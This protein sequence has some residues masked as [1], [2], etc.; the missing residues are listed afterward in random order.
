MT[1]LRRATAVMTVGTVFSRITGVLRLAAVLGALGV[2]SQ[3]RLADTYNI[4]NTAPNIIYELVLGGVITSVFVPIFVELL[5]TEGRERAWEVASAIINLT[6][7]AL[8]AMTILGILA[9][10]LIA[11][12]YAS[13]LHGA[14]A[15]EQQ[16]VLTFLLRLFIPQIIFY[17]IY[18]VTAGLLN[19]HRRFGPPM[20]T[21]ALGNVAV[22]VIFVAF[23][24]AYGAVGGLSQVSNWQLILIG[25]GTTLGIVLQALTQLPFMRGLGR[26]RATL[27]VR[28]PSIRKLGRLAV[29]VIGYVVVNQI[30]Y[31]VVQKLADAQ[32][33]GYTA[34]AAA[35][36]FYM[37]PH[38]LFAVSVAT[39]LLPE[40]SA[41]A[42]NDRWDL[43]RDRLSTG[44]RTTL[45]L[46]L[47]A[48]VGY[49]V[50][51]TPIIRLLLEHGVMQAS[52]VDLVA[53]VLRYFVLGL[54]SF[55]LFQ[56]LLRAFYALQDT[57]T[58]FL[59]NCWW[60]A[61]NIGVNFPLFFWFRSRG[62]GVEGLALGHAIAYT[63]GTVLL[64]RALSKKAGGISGA[65]FFASA[66]RITAAAAGMGAAVWATYAGLTR[67][68]P[69]GS[70][71]DLVE[72]IVPV[73]VGVGCY[74]GLALAFSVEELA[75]VK[76]IVGRRGR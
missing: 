7:V 3:G 72:V 4:G 44:M 40:M 22:I 66:G 37:L 47:P 23:Y 32:L 52:D 18:S 70:A 33:G 14:A 65:K 30:G 5:E 29:F 1:S 63:V 21:P 76:G 51:A 64:W 39:A 10:P 13:S 2:V 43:Y 26:Y 25:G 8:T 31:L 46:I 75:F 58:P 36:T 11:K 19:A 27:S 24:F 34:Y 69:A 12:F 53:R 35:F 62:G 49:F 50:L 20:Y 71:G 17:G 28:H 6:I 67:V 41:H 68:L 9:A 15:A 55:S 60:L 42:V 38:G 59:I 48:A 54:V 61:V 16:H 45:L 73:T 74:L 57:R 56:L